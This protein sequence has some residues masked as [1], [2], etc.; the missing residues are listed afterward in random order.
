MVAAT[1]RLRYHAFTL[2]ELLVVIAIIGILVALL[3]PAV[4][5]AREAARRSECGNNLKQLALSLH[6]FESA[7]KRLPHGS[8][9]AAGY[10]S[11]HIQLANHFE[12]TSV[13]TQVDWTVGPF[14][15]PNYDAARAQPKH[16]ICPSDPFPGR[17]NDM[18]WT[19]YH[20]N[21]GSWVRI[22][23]W[24]GVFGPTYGA[25]GGQ[26]L[27]SLTLAEV[28][29]GLSN[30][31][32]FAEVVNGVGGPLPRE[33]FDCFETSNPTATDIAGSRSHFLLQ[34]WQT[35]NI[36]WT[37]T[38]RWRG[39]PW[40]E[41]TMWRNW[42]NHLLGPNAP[43]WMT[44]DWWQLV[45]PASSYHPGGVLVALCDGSVRFANESVDL[46]VWVAA[47]TRRG[48]ESMPLP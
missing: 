34:D 3:L 7:Y 15:Q 14:S 18:G 6:N 5:A 2:V 45:S 9:E 42:Y 8:Y 16:L 10:L 39:Y 33:R 44:G 23:G 21:A 1:T 26:A 4:Q 38:W 41:G 47:G 28:V 46:D 37:G 11:P 48:R 19:N 17:I 43:C 20:S 32:A 25:G 29:D 35:A 12:Q 22:R 24:D 40:T 27:K 30:T 36:P 31:A 13:V